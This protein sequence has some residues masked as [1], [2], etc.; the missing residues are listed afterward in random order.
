MSLNLPTLTLL[1]REL[2]AITDRLELLSL[3]LYATKLS[4]DM[5]M[6]PR[7][8]D[9]ASDSI[10]LAL[11]DVRDAI[12]DQAAGLDASM[13]RHPAGSA[14]DTEDPA[15]VAEHALTEDQA[16]TLAAAVGSPD[17]FGNLAVAALV[18][19]P[20]RTRAALADIA[21]AGVTL[22]PGDHDAASVEDQA[23]PP[24]APVDLGE[25]A[26]EPGDAVTFT[27]VEVEMKA[28]DAIIERTGES[29]DWELL[30][31]AVDVYLIRLD[32]DRPGGPPNRGA[33]DAETAD[34][35]VEFVVSAVEA[36][37]MDSD[38]GEAP[39]TLTEDQGGPQ[40]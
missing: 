19:D 13:S 34:A 15:A 5:R 30:S 18:A 24:A 33:I 3:W 40:R 27:Q 36:G 37:A 22:A 16:D 28:R 12:A 11:L 7:D 9:A 2:E 35:V 31:D 6:I 10:A 38:T 23:E 26:G 8:I 4:H 21:N 29:V 17:D 14:L 39:D 1:A 25:P 32:A 20:E